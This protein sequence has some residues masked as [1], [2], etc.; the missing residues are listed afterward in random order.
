MS[1][2]QSDYLLATKFHLRDM[3]MSAEDANTLRR[4]Q[5]T[6][7]R[8]AELECGD[9]NQWGAWC[10]TRDEKTDKPLM[11]RHHYGKVTSTTTYEPIPDREKGALGRVA[12]LCE[13]LG[14]YYYHQ[15]DPRGC[16]LYVSNKP[17]NDRNYTEGVACCA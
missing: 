7:H 4:A 6:L 2:R 3:G 8:W 9:S 10:I 12:A 11:E 16:A 5:L 15:T 14:L 13:R 17:L 1:A